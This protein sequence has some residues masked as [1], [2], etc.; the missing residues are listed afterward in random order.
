VELMSPQ[1]FDTIYESYKADIFRFLC[2]LVKDREEA[3]DIFQE[4]WLRVIRHGPPREEIQNLKPWLLT[5]VLNL[6]R[7]LL[8]KKRLRSFF[9]LSWKREEGRRARAAEGLAP[10]S[11]DPVYRSEQVFLQRNIHEAIAKLPERQRR[12]FLLKEVEG[13]QQAEIASAMG[14]PVGTVKSLMHRAVKSLRRELA[15]NASKGVSVKCD[16]KMLSV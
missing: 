14:I 3:E 6:H 11:T 4:V 15:A 8:R 2:Y 16:A 1:E 5:V 10:L 9:L 12:I 7:D 13:Y